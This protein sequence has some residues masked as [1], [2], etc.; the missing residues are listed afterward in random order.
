MLRVQVIAETPVVVTVVTSTFQPT[1]KP[2]ESA[3]VVN[4]IAPCLWVSS[5]PD[6]M[7]TVI[8]CTRVWIR[9]FVPSHYE[10]KLITCRLAKI[11]HTICLTEWSIT[12]SSFLLPLPYSFSYNGKNDLETQPRSWCEKLLHDDII[13]VEK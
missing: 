9:L 2:G 1:T 13:Y 8:F 6:I 7:N 10:N 12:T 3:M 11:K 4:S 5:F